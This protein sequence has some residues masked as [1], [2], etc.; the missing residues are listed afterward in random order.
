MLP[1]TVVALSSFGDG[2]LPSFLDHERSARYTNS[3]C[4]SDDDVHC[5]IGSGAP[6]NSTAAISGTFG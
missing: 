5:N 3:A 1:H 6:G 2:E 4:D